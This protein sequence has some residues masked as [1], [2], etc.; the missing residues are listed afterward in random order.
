MVMTMNFV[1][2]LLFDPDDG[3][4]MCFLNVRLSLNYITLQ[5]RR[6]YTVPLQLI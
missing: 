1:D 3:G 4:K 5:P 2:G 6:L